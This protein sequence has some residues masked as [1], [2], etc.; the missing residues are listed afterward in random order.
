MI[1]EIKQNCI[2]NNNMGNICQPTGVSNYHLSKKGDVSSS[3]FLL[4]TRSEHCFC[5]TIL[6]V[7][8]YSNFLRFCRLYPVWSRTTIWRC[9]NIIL[10]LGCR[11]MTSHNFWHQ[12]QQV[13]TDTDYI[14]KEHILK[15]MCINL[16]SWR[17]TKQNN[18]Q[19][20]DQYITNKVL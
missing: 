18:A 16:G 20:G 9:G 17:S 6:S 4:F 1:L 12:S 3:L 2:D 10:R 5:K 8:F 15:Q 19:Y 7:D 11:N 13:T 14:G